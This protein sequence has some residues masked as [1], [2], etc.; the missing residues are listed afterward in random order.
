[1]RDAPADVGAQTNFS[2]PRRP[3][4][5]KALPVFGMV[6]FY[7]FNWSDRLSSAVGYSRTDITNSDGQLPTAF[8]AGQYALANLLFY[9]VKNVM[10]GLEVQWGRRQNFSDG[11]GV[12]DF[13]V[14]F[15]ARY[16]FSM[17]LGTNK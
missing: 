2:D 15:S 7:D 8:R 4:V 3:V 11:F 17:E 16:N 12:N 5:G 9:P 10:T 13:R 14:Q 1:M 6:A